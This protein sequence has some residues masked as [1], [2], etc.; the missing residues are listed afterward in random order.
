M[1]RGVLDFPF[2]SMQLENWRQLILQHQRTFIKPKRYP[3]TTGK[4]DRS[5]HKNASLYR[6]GGGKQKSTLNRFRRQ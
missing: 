5:L 3:E 6:Q 4:A 1:R 2:L